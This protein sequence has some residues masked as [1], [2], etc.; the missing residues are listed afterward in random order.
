MA[1]AVEPEYSYKGEGYGEDL[2]KKGSRSS[3]GDIEE[4]IIQGPE[5]TDP[6]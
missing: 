1:T 6:Q 3:P 4:N 5:T 2:E